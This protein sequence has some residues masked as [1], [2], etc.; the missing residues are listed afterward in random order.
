MPETIMMRYGR[1]RNWTVKD[2]VIVCAA[3][4]MYIVLKWILPKIFPALSHRLVSSIAWGVT[5]VIMIA[6]IFIT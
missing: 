6:L 3:L 2:F 1:Y 4:V 5:I